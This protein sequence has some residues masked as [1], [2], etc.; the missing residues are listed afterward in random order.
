MDS[1]V[2]LHIIR[3]SIGIFVNVNQAANKSP[4]I[5]QPFLRLLSASVVRQKLQG[6]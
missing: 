1:G 5:L 4:N 6:C 3:V 2:P